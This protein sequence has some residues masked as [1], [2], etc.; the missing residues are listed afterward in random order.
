MKVYA[1][2]KEML[3]YQMTVEQN[4]VHCVSE[5]QRRLP[6][7]HC[8][9]FGHNMRS[10][11]QCLNVCPHSLPFEEYFAKFN[12]NVNIIFLPPTVIF[13]LWGGETST[14]RQKSVHDRPG[15]MA[16]LYSVLKASQQRS[17]LCDGRATRH[18]PS[19]QLNF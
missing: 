4:T 12:I 7:C 19:P 2:L 17:I 16:D 10:S 18:T 14:K 6:L 15:V 11:F 3:V 1:M 8:H 5:E 9:I 13:R